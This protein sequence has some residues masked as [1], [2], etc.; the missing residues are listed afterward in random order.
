MKCQLCDCLSYG[1]SICRSEEEYDVPGSALLL[2]CRAAEAQKLKATWRTGDLWN[3][4]SVRTLLYEFWTWYLIS[5]AFQLTSCCGTHSISWALPLPG[6]NLDLQEL[7]WVSA[8]ICQENL[9]VI[10]EMGPKQKKGSFSTLI[11]KPSQIHGLGEWHQA[12]SYFLFMVCMC[13]GPRLESRWLEPRWLE[14]AEL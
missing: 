11:W 4:C 5:A 3:S 12:C 7:L 8:G 13:P 9:L 10:V 14:L 2:G 1:E 6:G